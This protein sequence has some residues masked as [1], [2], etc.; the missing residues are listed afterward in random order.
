MT[1]LRFHLIQ[2]G[3][4][5]LLQLADLLERADVEHRDRGEKTY[6]QE[7][8]AHDCGTPACA[9]G[10]WVWAER[11]RLPDLYDYMF[12][13]AFMNGAAP[14]EAAADEFHISLNEVR[15]LFGSDGCNY[16]ETAREAAAYIRG[17]VMRKRYERTLEYKLRWLLPGRQDR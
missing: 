4:Q 12:R 10:H 8:Y 2:Q 3:E 9:L 7:S 13:D 1:F 14:F 6:K 17:F 5:R 15:E 11:D 16:A